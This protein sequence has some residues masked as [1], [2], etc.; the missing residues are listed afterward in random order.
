MTEI[1]RSPIRCEAHV[2]EGGPWA[3]LRLPE[4]ASAKLPSRG[5]VAA[6]VVV[7]RHDFQ[8]VLEPDGER[9]HWLKVDKTLREAVGVSPDGT[10]TLEIY[11]TKDWPEPEVPLDF[12]TA[13][14]DA[15]DIDERWKGITPMARL[16]MGALDKC[17]QKP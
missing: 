10:V 3:I 14:A 6:T 2:Y 8:A 4:G 17:N 9:G 1:N 12:A 7:N 16:G 11:P 5:Q 13:L 15:S